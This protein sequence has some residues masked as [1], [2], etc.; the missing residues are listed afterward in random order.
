MID[1]NTLDVS[2]LAYQCI[3][4]RLNV[5]DYFSD[6]DYRHKIQELTRNFIGGFCIFGGTRETVLLLT[7]EL[8][9]LA[10]IPLLFCADFEYGLKM[11]LEDGGEYPHA[12]A[13]GKTK[14]P[15]NAYLVAKAIATEAKSIGVNWN[16]APVCDINSNKENPIINIRSYGE[17][18]DEVNHFI[19]EY[20][21]GTQEKNVMACAKHFPGHGD[22]NVD[23]HM[24][25]PIINK[26]KEELESLE[27]K[28]FISAINQ[29]VKSVMVA[30]L[31]LPQIDENTLPSTLSSKL[32]RDY[33]I[34]TLGFD[35]LIVSDAL[36]MNALKSFSRDEEPG[37]SA[38]KAGCDVLLI[39]ENPESLVEAIVKEAHSDSNFQVNLKDSCTKILQAKRWCGLFKGYHNSERVDTLQ[40]SKDA[41]RIAYNA[42]NIEG[43]KKLIPIGDDARLAAFAIIQ[44]SMDKPVEL[45]NML[46]Q[47]LEN[48]I[49]FGFIDSNITD[50]QVANFREDTSDADLIILPVFIK[51]LAYHGSVAITENISNAVRRISA[52][53]PV[54]TLFLGSPYVS[55]SLKADL[56]IFTYSDS[57]PS[58]AAAVMV[59]TGRNL[60]FL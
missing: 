3:F 43:D 34:D 37:L 25:L 13:V 32:I 14:N 36:D 7:D 44:D 53:R 41:L 40:L 60:E 31:G 56:N 28:P 6:L 50:E 23:S 21:R 17:S 33:L 15:T 45:F 5:P 26:S 46:S 58:L 42:I 11:R 51:S 20:I 4:P 24:S 8:Q 49:D 29:G 47:A 48:D 22:T 35:W 55:D 16:L 38:K 1:V 18:V 57:M 19:N 12:M 10:P 59:L 52:G 54:I 9:L 30:H 2:D 27:I 39:P